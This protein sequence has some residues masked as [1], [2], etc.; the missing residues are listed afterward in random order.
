LPT[1][2]QHFIV[3]WNFAEYNQFY[4]ATVFA[5]ITIMVGLL[6]KLGAAPFHQ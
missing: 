2:P 4:F 6:I 5:I 1:Q 3:A